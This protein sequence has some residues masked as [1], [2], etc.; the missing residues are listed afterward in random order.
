MAM[1]QNTSVKDKTNPQEPT[2]KILEFVK[3]LRCKI[4]QNDIDSIER[5]ND[6]MR[7]ARNMRQGIKR[8]TDF[9]YPDA[10]DIPLPQTDKIIR[11]HKPRYVLSVISGKRLMDI[12]PL[13]GT[14]VIN[15]ELQ[16]KA[17]KA[18]LAMNW[19]FRRHSMEWIK[20]LTLNAD[21]VLEKGYCVFKIFEKFSSRMVSKVVDI[22]EFP[23]EEVAAFKKLP[24][25]E[26]K[27]FIA[28][29]YGLDP[30][31]EDDKATLDKVIQQFNSGKKVIRFTTEEIISLP[32]VICP[33]P[34]KV[35]VPKGTTEID[36]AQRIT[37][38]FW[39]TE[40]ELLQLAHNN[41]LIKDKVLRI[42]KE[43]G[44]SLKRG[45][46]AFNEKIKDRMEGIDDSETGGELYCIHETLTW[47]QKEEGDPYEAWVFTTFR[48]VSD[49]KDA[50]IQWM[51]YPYEF[52]SWNYVKHDNEIIDDRFRS[53]R[54]IPEQIR[55][56]QEMMEK[57]INNML[58][59]DEMQNAPMWTVKNN[60]S[61]ISDT[62]RF[63]PGQRIPVNNHDD[64]QALTSGNPVDLSSERILTL[65]K[66]Y[67]EEYVGITD[68]L[69]K[70]PANQSGTKTMG[71]IQIGIGE[72]QF[73]INLDIMNWTESIRKVYEK[74]FYILQER[75][76]T[77]LYIDGEVITREDFMFDPDISVNGSLEM[78][79]KMLQQQR[80]QL[81]LERSRQAVQ[82]GVATLDD[83][84]N[85]YRDY[86]EKDGV[87]E[88]DDY[89]TN[90][91]EIAQVKITQLQN[92][93]MQLQGIVADAH[94][95]IAQADN[96]LRQIQTQIIRKGGASGESN[97]N[98]PRKS[99]PANI[100]NPQ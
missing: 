24:I 14:Q 75:L 2:E 99:Q 80:A 96:T 19:I 45:E 59:R 65:L 5:W 67:S 20:K 95:E 41:I 94:S 98:Q 81:R 73:A 53:S 21:R 22:N 70:N 7:I 68:Q 15:P 50:L 39:W 83:L 92:Q 16:S 64:I 47:F 58:I 79:D 8:V 40:Q 78:A 48:D 91:S 74:V 46:D 88:P 26:K 44:D 82:D 42:I 6:K 29:R 57:S 23:Q 17:R 43:K 34:E 76:V 28:D 56:I 32:E 12:K 62:V 89:I 10:P 55:A 4:K 77:P 25:Q 85:A 1:K 71:E 90:P 51:P 13:E 3:D 87:K 69:F 100:P 93:V 60:L 35:Y 49:E 72:T 61:L 66:A 97:G 9:P 63:I 30:E 52:D 27:E 18:T 31:N 37:H 36:K 11:K 54:G 33:A 86:L 38:E 84:F